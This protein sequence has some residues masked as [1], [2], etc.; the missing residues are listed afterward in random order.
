ML[1]YKQISVYL[2]VIVLRCCIY[3]ATQ[4]DHRPDPKILGPQHKNSP[5]TTF[6][7]ALRNNQVH[8]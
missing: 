6:P 8:I 5:Y 3:Y 2:F 7:V 1:S 4:Q